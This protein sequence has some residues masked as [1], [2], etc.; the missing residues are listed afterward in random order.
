MTGRA[1]DFQ[2]LAA[3]VVS[4]A[5]CDAAAAVPQHLKK[6]HAHKPAVQRFAPSPMHYVH[7][8]MALGEGPCG[9]DPAMKRL[10]RPDS[11]RPAPPLD[12]W[13]FG[14]ER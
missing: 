9:L 6:G 7:C 12:G 3:F 11:A 13:D 4:M 5:L 10:R 1:S 14:P 2:A 8:A